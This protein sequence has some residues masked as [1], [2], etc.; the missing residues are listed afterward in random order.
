MAGGAF[1][2]GVAGGAGGV[3]RTGGVCGGGEAGAAGCASA[4]WPVPRSSA[5]ATSERSLDDPGTSSQSA[6]PTGNRKRAVV[7]EERRRRAL[8]R[9][10][11]LLTF[12]AADM[13]PAFPSSGRRRVLRTA[14]LVLGT[15]A[16]TLLVTVVAMNLSS[17]DKRLAYRLAHRYD[18]EDPQFERSFTGEPLRH[19]RGRPAAASASATPTS[20]PTTSPCGPCWRPAAAV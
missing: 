11:R 15:V 5:R 4:A 7:H 3:G 20:C 18:V 19:R 12:R 13:A 1:G 9:G 14:L 8:P 16:L 17:G 6:A 2:T 10:C